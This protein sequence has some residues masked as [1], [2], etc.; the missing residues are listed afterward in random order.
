MR[1][2]LHIINGYC[3][4][5]VYRNLVTI[6]DSLG[7]RQ[8]IYIP[9]RSLKDQSR[10]RNF[11]LK[12]SI[13]YYS[14]IFKTLFDRLFFFRKIRKI[15]R[16]IERNKDFSHDMLIHAHTLFSDGGVA[17]SLHRK[18]K[19]EYLV[20]VRNTDVNFF[21][22]Y[23]F[24]LRGYGENI[25]LQAK[26]VI[27]LSPGYQETVL[28]KYVKTESREKIERKSM[29]IP[30]GTDAFWQD[31]I[32]QRI[33]ANDLKIKLIY[34]GEIRRNKNIHNTIKAVE[35]LR[36]GGLDIRLW[37]IGY[38]LND[39]IGYVRRIRKICDSLPYVDA[40]DQ[41][42]NQEALMQ[43]YRD[44]DIFIMPSFTETFGLVY[45]EA[46]SQGL[47]LIYSKGQGIDGYFG[48]GEAGYAVDPHDPED[49]AGKVKEILQRYLKISNFCSVQ[50]GQFNWDRIG[51]IYKSLY[52]P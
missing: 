42:Q 21:Y 45:A 1:N 43:Y 29:I 3:G 36:K 24:F 35:L 38:G 33:H 5:K 39:E 2:I 28:K 30:N 27:F 15:S 44:A 32:F 17:L 8:L 25:M 16:D 47:P 11:E 51:A 19:M 48:D 46:M 37:V 10:F 22:K 13:Y 49:I 26:Q 7:I 14:H 6:L 40:V 9:I 18:Y 50:A 52:E 41:V 12:N 4:N 31:H 23:F 34:V 20:A